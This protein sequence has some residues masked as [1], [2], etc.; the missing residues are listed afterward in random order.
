MAARPGVLWHVKSVRTA[1]SRS[2]DIAEKV[3][4]E[5]LDSTP[6]PSGAAVAAEVGGCAVRLDTRLPDVAQVRVYAQCIM[7]DDSGLPPRG[8]QPTMTPGSC[9]AQMLSVRLLLS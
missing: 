2:R 1:P 8:C 6:R 5:G 9:C 3:L 4:S 7:P